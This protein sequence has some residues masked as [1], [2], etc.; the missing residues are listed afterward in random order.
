MLS[1]VLFRSKFVKSLSHSVAGINLKTAKTPES[2]GAFRRRLLAKTLERL[3]LRVPEELCNHSCCVFRAGVSN[4]I[5][6]NQNRLQ[7]GTNT[8]P[9]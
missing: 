4:I 7:S 6:V 5:P 8:D 3:F 2:G 1:D 9:R